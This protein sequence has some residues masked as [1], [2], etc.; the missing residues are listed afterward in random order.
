MARSAVGREL[1]KLGGSPVYREGYLTDNGNIIL[2]V[3]Q[4]DLVNPSEMEL[5]INQIVGVIENGI[6]A[7]RPANLLL[8][9]TQNGIEKHT[10]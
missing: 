10:F 7:Q 6:F 3:Y 9:A 4:L 5:R 2:D 8:L 1:V